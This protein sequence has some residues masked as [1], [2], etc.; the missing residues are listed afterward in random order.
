MFNS[1]SISNPMCS[2]NDYILDMLLYACC[3]S[4]VLIIGFVMGLL[5]NPY[6][7][8]RKKQAPKKNQLMYFFAMKAKTVTEVWE[9]GA[10]QTNA[11]WFNNPPIPLQST[12]ETFV[13]INIWQCDMYNNIRFVTQN[14]SVFDR[15]RARLN[16]EGI[17]YTTVIKGL[18]CSCHPSEPNILWSLDKNVSKS[19]EEVHEE[20][21]M[22]GTQIQYR[23]MTYIYA[24]YA[25]YYIDISIHER[26]PTQY[27]ALKNYL[28]VNN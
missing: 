21:M 22:T 6:L 28:L 25:H 24:G 1:S 26:N 2:K 4:L 27:K 14:R 7:D 23:G 3:G 12:T 10:S 5:C 15:E 20:M 8:A 16:T 18:F 13:Y 17:S 19:L 9:I 11:T